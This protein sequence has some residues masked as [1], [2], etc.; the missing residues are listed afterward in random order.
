[1]YQNVMNMWQIIIMFGDDY[2]SFNL[3][4]FMSFFFE[5]IPWKLKFSSN[6]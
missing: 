4:I 2:F 6:G 5:L 1:M 3:I